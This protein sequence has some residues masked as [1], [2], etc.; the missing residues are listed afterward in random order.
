MQK[1]TSAGLLKVLG[2]VSLIM[3]LPMLGG[4]VAGIAVDAMLGTSPIFV[5]G[6][7]IVGTIGSAI[8]IWLYIR[9]RRPG[10]DG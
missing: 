6:G 5:V 7:L 2:H 1:Q 8:G 4:G 9:A 10:A 3:W